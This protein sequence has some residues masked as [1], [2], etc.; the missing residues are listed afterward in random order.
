MLNLITFYPILMKILLVIIISLIIYNFKALARP[1]KSVKRNTWFILLLIFLLGFGLRTWYVPHTHYVYNDEYLHINIAQNILYSGEMC[2]CLMGSNTECSSCDLRQWPGGYHTLLSYMFMFFGDS[3]GVAFNLNAVLA[4]LSIM[5]VFLVTYMMFKNQ[6]YALLGSFMFTFIP[7]HLKFSGTNALNISSVFFVLL[8]MLFLEIFLAKRRYAVFLLLLATLLYAVNI[9]VEN[10]LLI[11]VLLLYAWLRLGKGIKELFK[12][13]YIIAGLVFA[14][15]LVPLAQLWNH[16]RNV[17]RPDGWIDSFAIK[18]GH[19]KNYFIP[20]LMFFRNYS[21]NSIFF[22][23]LVILGAFQIYSKD[24]KRFYYYLSFFLLFFLMFTT[25]QK[26]DFLGFPDS[27]RYSLILYVPLLFFSVCGIDFVFEKFRMDKKLV[28]VLII[29]LYLATLL[30]TNGFVLAKRGSH[31]EEYKFIL[32]VQDKIPKDVYIIT[33]NPPMIIASTHRK[34]IRSEQFIRYRKILEPENN[35][36]LY[37]GLLGGW[38]TKEEHENFEAG[39][40][41]DYDFDLLVQ[42]NGYVFYNLTLK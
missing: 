11:P 35:F 13:K 31:Y 40:R 3:E 6:T 26:G 20:N 15:M 36:V 42:Y 2:R 16:S 5:F 9:R 30:P 1:F 22:P 38:L 24:K 29:I 37:K 23:L 18:L 8:V 12:I 14:A 32:E 19:L 27:I 17:I 21:Y 33:D 34:S 7:V 25:F 10:I 41:E 39:L 4:S 28:I